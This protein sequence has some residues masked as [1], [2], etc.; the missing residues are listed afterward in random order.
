MW[1]NVQAMSYDEQNTVLN[2]VNESLSVYAKSLENSLGNISFSDFFHNKM[3]IVKA[4]GKGIPFNI[5]K[6]IKSFTPFSD[7]DWADYL[8]I[9]LKSLHRYRDDEAHCFKSIHS[10]KIIELAEVTNFG[11]GVFGSSEKFYAWLQTPSYALD[12]LKPAELIK[13]S[14]GKEMVMAELNRIEHGIFA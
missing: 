10:E 13:N 8:D 6:Q 14:Y 4:I 5:F 1:T 12:G 7:T 9:S 3:L 2:H 11:I